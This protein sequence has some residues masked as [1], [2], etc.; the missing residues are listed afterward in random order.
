MNQEKPKVVASGKYSVADTCK[1]L[2][3]HR[4]TLRKY[5]QEGAIKC[6]YY[7]STRTKF[8]YGS[9][10]LKFWTSEL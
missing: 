5:T 6:G 10:I 9:E 8:Y 4:N 2:G 3:I 1:I 7:K